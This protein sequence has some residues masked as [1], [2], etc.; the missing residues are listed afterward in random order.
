VRHRDTQ[1]GEVLELGAELRQA[2]GDLDRA[3]LA[4]LNRERRAL[5]T[6][7]SGIAS[8]L[9]RELGHPLSPSVM[10]EVAQ[11]LQAAMSDEDAAN[12]LLSGRLVRSL[13]A[14]GFEPVDLDGAVAAP[15]PTS[16]AA[17]AAAPKAKRAVTDT[18][19]VESARSALREAE[20]AEATAAA[21]LE[22]VDRRMVRLGT[23]RD[24]LADERA[25]LE[26][27][28]R[29]VKADI[30]AAEREARALDKEHD[31]AA[32]ASERASAAT[33]QARAALA[34]LEG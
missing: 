31:T 6:A 33:E 34:K 3:S 13:T 30:G 18:K 16:R 21:E 25:E 9:A 2:Q 26:D 11:T 12:A 19:A 32:S 4:A 29:A 17:R 24:R 10:E 5:V 7:V 1:I 22:Q 14:V 23:R 28:L 27:Q 20:R 8:D 15:D